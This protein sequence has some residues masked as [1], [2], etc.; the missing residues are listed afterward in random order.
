MT[1]EQDANRLS[2]PAIENS[3]ADELSAASLVAVDASDIRICVNHAPVIE[4][5]VTNMRER[6]GLLSRPVSRQETVTQ[7]G[8][9]SGQLFTS[10]QICAVQCRGW[11]P[12]DATR[13]PTWSGRVHE[14]KCGCLQGVVSLQLTLFGPNVSVIYR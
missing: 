10:H 12:I 9:L 3:L 1:T 7:P 6:N 4:N 2:A 13:S 11:W 8:P 14:G 5:T